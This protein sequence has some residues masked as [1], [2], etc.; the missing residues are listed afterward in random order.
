MDALAGC[1]WFSTLDLC[2]GQW[3]VAM[4]EED[5]P[6]TTFS[7]GNGLRFGRCN[8]P[9]TFEWLMEK[10]LSGLPWEV[11]LLYS[12]DIIVHGREFREVIQ[13][14]RTLLQRLR[15]AGLKFSPKKC[16][17]F[18]NPFLFL[19]MWWAIMVYL[20]T[21]RGSTYLALPTD[22]KACQ[23][24]HG[25][26]LLLQTLCPWHFWHCQTPLQANQGPKRI[27]VDQRVWECISPAK[28]FVDNSSHF[29]LLNYRRPVH[30]RYRRKQHWPWRRTLSSPRGD[31]KVIACHSRSLRKI[32]RN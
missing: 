15:N 16:I 32:E 1:S 12:D 2:S 23:K 3:Q 18:R 5:R 26:P 31:E 6:K 9:A 11:C 19:A 27:P 20:P 17:S 21:P 25:S 28:S 30:S 14:L 10:V 7:T 13:R 24:L 4:N 29:G 22:S 8:A